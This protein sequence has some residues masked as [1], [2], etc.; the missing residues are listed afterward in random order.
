MMSA[1]PL[2]GKR[3]L[4]TRAKAQAANFANQIRALGG[5]P[6]VIPLIKIH[7]PTDRTPLVEAVND[8]RSF[9]W[10]VFTSQN[11]VKAFFSIVHTE[12][13]PSEWL[14]NMKI[15]VVGEK[16]REPVEV[17]GFDA[18]VIP[19]GDY[20]AEALA[21][22]LLK[23]VKRGERVLFPKGNLA[24]DVLPDSLRQRG[25]HVEDVVAYETG[26]NEEAQADLATEV[27]SERL[28]VIAFTSPSTVNHFVTLLDSVDWRSKINQTCLAAI[29]P[30]TERAMHKHGLTPNV[31]ANLNTTEGLLQ[32]VVQFL[33][34]EEES[35]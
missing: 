19:A 15:A 24:R 3:I 31:V 26:M 16:T 5:I 12:K 1:K 29:G 20:T 21:D 23:H 4:I 6:V 17:Q 14:D 32:E 10:L 25:I 13:I 27:T 35:K 7:H 30:I 18:H 8:M 33:N 28:D 11:G 2:E 9:D 34:N 22:E